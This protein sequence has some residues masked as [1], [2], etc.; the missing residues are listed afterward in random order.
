M[1]PR[2]PVSSFALTALPRSRCQFSSFFPLFPPFVSPAAPHVVARLWVYLLSQFCLCQV[3]CLSPQFVAPAF[4]FL[5]FYRLLCSLFAASFL[6][7]FS[8]QVFWF[9]GLLCDLIGLF[10]VRSLIKPKFYYKLQIIILITMGCRGKRR[11]SRNHLLLSVSWKPALSAKCV[12]L[13]WI[14]TLNKVQSNGLTSC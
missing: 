10:Q 14:G 11:I 7:K 6:C 3:I 8:I 9:F 13:F 12:N 4:S 2:T 5:F 1:S